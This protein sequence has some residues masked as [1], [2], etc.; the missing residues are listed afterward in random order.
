MAKHT[1]SGDLHICHV[2]SGREWGGGEHQV[3]HLVRGLHG[4]GI[5][6]TLLAHPRGALIDQARKA[7]MNTCPLPEI[8]FMALPWPCLK[9]LAGR[10][11]LAPSPSLHRL[12]PRLYPGSIGK[13]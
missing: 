9:P 12:G 10:V 7:G 13:W 4:H 3:M 1:H 2:N 8:G 11:R 5:R 6:S